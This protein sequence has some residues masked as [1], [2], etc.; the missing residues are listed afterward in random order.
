MDVI[1]AIES[2]G[3]SEL[4]RLL[5]RAKG[6]EG[7]AY[8]MEFRTGPLTNDMGGFVEFHRSTSGNPD[9]GQ[10][11]SVS[12]QRGCPYRSEANDEVTG[13]F[14]SDFCP[15]G[16]VDVNEAFPLPN[17]T[18]SMSGSAL[19][20]LSSQHFIGVTGFTDD[21]VADAFVAGPTYASQGRESFLLLTQVGVGSF[22]R[23]L[24]EYFG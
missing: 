14:V 12:R 16:S 8:P 2:N 24:R 1:M 10:L 17:A 20:V 5:D 6:F 13:K 15:D 18:P 22:C 21:I 9:L 19:T 4:S 3:E 11:V 7:N 23:G